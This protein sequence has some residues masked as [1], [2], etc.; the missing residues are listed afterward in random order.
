MIEIIFRISIGIKIV[1][2]PSFFFCWP[3]DLAGA[4][5]G[6]KA[7]GLVFQAADL[8]FGCNIDIMFDGF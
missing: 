2:I 4:F 1:Q 5:A 6:M 7:G 8:F 3:P